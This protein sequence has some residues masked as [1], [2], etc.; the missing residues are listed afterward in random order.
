MS[1]ITRTVR[2]IDL[3]NGLR[4]PCIERGDTSGTPVLLL[5]GVT[6]SLRS[7]EPLLPH[8][9]DA[10]RAVTVTQRGHAGASQP[11]DG[12]RIADLAADAIAVLDALDI[13]HA[14]LVG[15][16]MGSVVAQRVALDHPRRVRGLALL[17]SF[18]RMAGNREVLNLAAEVA[19][20]RD[21]IDV[22][23]VRAFQASTLARPVADAF[24]ARVVGDSLAVPAR[25]W[26]AL[27]D[28]FCRE[29]VAAELDR[30]AAPTL[31]IAGGRDAICSLDDQRALADRIPHAALHVLP[32]AGHAMHWE[33]P[34]GVAGALARFVY[35]RC[36]IV[37][38]DCES[39]AF[40]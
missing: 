15:H 11:A 33:D 37:Q 9:P 31:V 25:I 12:Y 18:S 1:S 24:F 26:R 6:D 39:V 21:P 7:W 5:H 22:E 13:E 10:V 40:R 8:L 4:L 27:F 32:E 29:D 19:A 34:V 17:G 23:F 14:V 38:Q 28:G 2:V 30:I 16:S 3:P 20:L 36:R 35:D